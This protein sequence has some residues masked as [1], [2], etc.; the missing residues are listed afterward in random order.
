MYVGAHQIV[1]GTL[2]AG[3]FFSYTF[4][5][6]FLIAPIM[7]IVSIGTQLT[8][9]LAGLERTQEIMRE[10]PEDQDPKRS[11]RLRD[12]V[13]THRVRRCEFQL[14]RSS[15][16]AARHF[17]PR[18]AGNGDGAGRFVGLGKVDDHRPDLR[19]LCAHAKARILVDGMDL[20]TVRLDSYRT[21]LGVVLQE[22]F[23]FDG[24]IRENVAFSRPDAS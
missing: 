9:A 7:Q 2:T 22:S 20:S 3:G 14:R 23:L 6:G 11:V 16:S 4:L 8:E 21:R 19:F 15:R 13:G 5:L 24:T 17:L 18:R 12:I 1:A 10:R